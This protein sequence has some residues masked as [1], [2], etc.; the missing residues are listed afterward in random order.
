M[1]RSILFSAILLL[2]FTALLAWHIMQ[3]KETEQ[4]RVVRIADGDSFTV[5]K[6][7]DELEVRLFGI[8]APEREQPYYRKAGLFTEKFLK[9]GTIRV[10]AIDRDRFGRTVA[11]V[12]VD[13]LNLNHVLVGHGLAWHFTRYSSDTTLARLEDS[14][15]AAKAGLWS[16]PAPV[17]PWEFRKRKR[18][19]M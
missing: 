1:K 4:Y 7:G 16:D 12:Y 18:G 11:W 8:D 3:E 9:K 5:S 10:E 14:A 13:S 2:L 17:P 15:R 6:N 19:Q